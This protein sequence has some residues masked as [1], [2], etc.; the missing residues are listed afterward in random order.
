MHCCQTETVSSHIASE[1]NLTYLITTYNTYCYSHNFACKLI[2]FFIH[3]P[4]V[5]LKC[6]RLLKIKL[7]TSENLRWWVNYI[8]VP[9][10]LQQGVL[11]TQKLA[12]CCDVATSSLDAA[13]LKIGKFQESDL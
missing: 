7:S 8:Y 9:S 3:K 6:Y 11:L 4:V 5:F 2:L 13:L 1:R 10:Y 12:A